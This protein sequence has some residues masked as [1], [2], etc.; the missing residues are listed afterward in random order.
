MGLYFGLSVLT[1]YEFCVFVFVKDAAEGIAPPPSRA[2]LYQNKE[3]KS[4]DQEIINPSKQD[5][6]PP[7]F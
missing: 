5:V 3:K 1:I 7:P 4:N 6:P 2:N